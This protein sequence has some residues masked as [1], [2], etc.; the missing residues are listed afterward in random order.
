MKKKK[1]TIIMIVAIIVVAIA[2]ICFGGCKSK[3]ACPA[4]TYA[5]IK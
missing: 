4:Y 2:S 1:M 3:K 5:V